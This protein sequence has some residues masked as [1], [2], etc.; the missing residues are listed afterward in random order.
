MGE[1]SE[2][3]TMLRPSHSKGIIENPTK[4]LNFSVSTR[5]PGATLVL[6]LKFTVFNLTKFPLALFN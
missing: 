5:A 4:K 2:I 3:P 1:S 6:G